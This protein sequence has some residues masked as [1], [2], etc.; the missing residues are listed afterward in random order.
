LHRVEV[1]PDPNGLELSSIDILPAVAYGLVMR[2]DDARRRAVLAYVAHRHV[3]IVSPYDE[4]RN[5]CGLPPPLLAGARVLAE[6]HV[7]G[8]EPCLPELA[9]DTTGGLLLLFQRM[10][11]LRV[12]DPAQLGRIAPSSARPHPS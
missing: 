8:A 6:G 9:P 12:S 4:Q 3:Q 11:I 7:F 5:R 10:S 2:S 1:P